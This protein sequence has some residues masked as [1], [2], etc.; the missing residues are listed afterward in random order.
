M[1]TSTCEHTHITVELDK[2][3]FPS[4]LYLVTGRLELALSVVNFARLL[5]K[6]LLLLLLAAAQLIMQ[7][8]QLVAYVISLTCH[9]KYKQAEETAFSCWIVNTGVG[10]GLGH[11]R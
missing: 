4:P 9:S 5:R 10:R 3:N 2:R 8:K 11:H 6:L 1:Q 7:C